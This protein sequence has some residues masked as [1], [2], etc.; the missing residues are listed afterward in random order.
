MNPNAE[1]IDQSCPVRPCVIELGLENCSQCADYPCEKFLERQVIF[2]EIQMRFGSEIPEE[3]RR[4][5]I[6][7]YENKERLKKNN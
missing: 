6:L 2:E 3:D 7:P 4:R 1:L 5:F